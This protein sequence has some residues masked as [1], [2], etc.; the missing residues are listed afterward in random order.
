MV[1]MMM[2]VRIVHWIQVAH[3]DVLVEI[4]DVGQLLLANVALINDIVGS[5][6]R[7]QN[8]DSTIL[9]ILSILLL[10]SQDVLLQIRLLRI[11]LQ[12]YVATVGTNSEMDHF[13]LLQ[14]CS[15]CKRLKITDQR[16]RQQLANAD[17]KG[18]RIYTP[19]H[20]FCT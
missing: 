9:S 17:K 6:G 1:M 15:L 7:W 20:N 10:M 8:R 5:R 19:Y 12:A 11:R 2:Q 16:K 14:I 4:A 13:V 18:K 3:F